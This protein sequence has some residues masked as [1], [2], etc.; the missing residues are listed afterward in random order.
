SSISCDGW[1]K[2]STEGGSLARQ[3]FDP[4]PS[5]VLKTWEPP[6]KL[7]RKRVRTC[8]AKNED[9]RRP[10]NSPRHMAQSDGLPDD[11]PTD[12]GTTPRPIAT[13]KIIR[14]V[15]TMMGNSMAV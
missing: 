12:G 13:S 6:P 9:L 5:R 10:G 8:R 14:P 3:A 15:S 2:T 7:A 11:G 4:L 1:A